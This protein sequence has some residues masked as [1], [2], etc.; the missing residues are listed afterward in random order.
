MLQKVNWQ[1]Y[2]HSSQCLNLTILYFI[3]SSF[4]LSSSFFF[5][6]FVLLSIFWILIFIVKFSFS[7]HNS[8]FLLIPQIIVFKSYL[9]LV[10]ILQNIAWFLLQSSAHITYVNAMG[11]MWTSFIFSITPSSYARSYIALRN[12]RLVELRH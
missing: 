6:I 11:F 5:G 3:T 2:S 10:I 8:F 9:F 12:M 1:L 4:F 7:S